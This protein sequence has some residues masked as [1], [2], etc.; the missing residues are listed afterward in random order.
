MIG[1]R[2]YS[3]EIQADIQ[4]RLARMHPDLAE[5]LKKQDAEVWAY[6]R[7]D[8]HFQTL[9]QHLADAN[10]A[11]RGLPFNDRRFVIKV[12]IET[13]EVLKKIDDTSI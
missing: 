1:E 12:L 2:E 11:M 9:C 10:E 7:S 13:T 4:A 5:L 8:E 6:A 3:P